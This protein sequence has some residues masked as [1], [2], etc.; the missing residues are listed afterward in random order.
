MTPHLAVAKLV[1][2]GGLECSLLL[3]TKVPKIIITGFIVTAWMVRPDY[4]NI[5]I[6][7]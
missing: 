6:A 1:R 3:I 4:E 2:G 5:D 7:K